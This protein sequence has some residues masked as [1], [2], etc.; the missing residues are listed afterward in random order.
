MTGGIR[1]QDVL[2][3][4]GKEYTLNGRARTVG[5]TP[6][7]DAGIDFLDANGNKIAGFGAG[8]GQTG[9]YRSFA[10]T[11][12]APA[13]TKVVRVWLYSGNSGQTDFDD[14]RLTQSGCGEPAPPQPPTHCSHLQN[15]DFSSGVA[16]W[17]RL[18]GTSAVSNGQLVLDGGTRAQDVTATAGTSYTFS[19]SYRTNGAWSRDVG[20]DFLGAG[21]NKLAGHSAGIGPSSTMTEFT[22]TATAPAGTRQARVWLYSGN[23]GTTTVDD[24]ELTS[25]C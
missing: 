10:T 14:I 18:W 12:T 21:G 15:G 19:G 7:R 3:S 8:V 11:K 24:V 6:S 2:G 5:S 17:T 13:G 16:S 9:A 22:V 25:S 1:V 4:A 20:I 23:T